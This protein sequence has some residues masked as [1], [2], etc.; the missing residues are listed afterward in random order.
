MINMPLLLIQDIPGAEPISLPGID[1]FIRRKDTLLIKPA[2]TIS[3][4]IMYV[5]GKVLCADLLLGMLGRFTQIHF[6]LGDE[7]GEDIDIEYIN[8]IYG[9]VDEFKRMRH[10]ELRHDPYINT[11][12]M[13]IQNGHVW[14]IDNNVEGPSLLHKASDPKQFY[15]IMKS[16]QD[17]FSVDDDGIAEFIRG[18]NDMK[19]MLNDPPL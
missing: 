11:G 17:V 9:D 3:R 15:F 1:D 10:K 13:L 2:N 6:Y 8:R 18:F 12:N 4:D 16:I 14:L 19:I 5:I 7:I